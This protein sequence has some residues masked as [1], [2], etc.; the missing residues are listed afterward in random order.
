MARPTGT[1]R[2]QGFTKH[3]R[4]L[5]EKFHLKNTFGLAGSCSCV[6]LHASCTATAVTQEFLF[7]KT[8]FVQLTLLG[9]AHLH[10]R[11][12]GLVS[13]ACSMSDTTSDATITACVRAG[14][15]CVSTAALGAT[16]LL[17][18]KSSFAAEIPVE[19]VGRIVGS[20]ACSISHVAQD[21]VTANIW[22][23][24]IIWS[25]VAATCRLQTVY[26]VSTAHHGGVIVPGTSAQRLQA[27][28]CTCV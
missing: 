9:T 11:I 8:S 25:T 20:T 26:L 23:W 3:S 17:P 14:V 22:R 19:A 18:P 7:A 2:T 27:A 16:V 5:A 28:V 4:N 12:K 15:D 13:A 21:I 1:Y 6:I 10:D 24:Q